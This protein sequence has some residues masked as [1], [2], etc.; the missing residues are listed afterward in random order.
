M[1]AQKQTCL[2]AKFTGGGGVVVA[3]NKVGVVAEGRHISSRETENGTVPNGASLTDAVDGARVD[4]VGVVVDGPGSVVRGK[5][6]NLLGDQVKSIFLGEETDFEVGEVR[7]DVPFG[8]SVLITN[9][10]CSGGFG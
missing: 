3:R 6:S 9:V 10:A 2:V 8:T 4:S 7:N 1:R 5:R